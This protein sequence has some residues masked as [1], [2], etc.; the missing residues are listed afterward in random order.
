MEEGLAEQMMM[1]QQGSEVPQG[2]AGMGGQGDQALVEQIVQLLLDGVDPEELLQNGVPQDLLEQAMQIVL[3]QTGGGGPQ[4]PM[5]VEP[6]TDAGLAA[7]A[8]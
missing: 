8:Y 7:T 5:M 3:Q 4:E 2:A 1:A 6:M